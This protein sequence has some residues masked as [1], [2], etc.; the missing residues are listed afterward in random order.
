MKYKQGDIVTIFEDPLTRQKPE[1]DVK[2][3][4]KQIAAKRKGDPEYWRV[5]FLEDGFVCDRFV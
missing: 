3:I 1:G 5:K 2:L 4:N